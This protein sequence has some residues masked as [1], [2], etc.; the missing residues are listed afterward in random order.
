VRNELRGYFCFF[1]V[2]PERADEFFAWPFFV[3]PLSLFFA[4]G[5]ASRL[6]VDSFLASFALS[7]LR[8]LRVVVFASALDSEAL[9]P[10]CDLRVDFLVVLGSGAFS[11]SAALA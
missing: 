8:D 7:P 3:S 4:L 6:F 1:L 11:V 2:L 5:A 9:A 10:R